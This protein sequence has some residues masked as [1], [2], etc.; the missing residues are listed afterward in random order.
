MSVSDLPSPSEGGISTAR[1]NASVTKTQWANY[2]LRKLREG[3]LLLE[4]RNGRVYHFLRTGEPM[5]PCATHAAKKLIEMGL[6]TVLKSD[7]RGTHYGLREAFQEAD[8]Q[9]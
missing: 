4:A 1:V 7:I 9:A 6:L 5:Q 3:Y 8:P 2:A